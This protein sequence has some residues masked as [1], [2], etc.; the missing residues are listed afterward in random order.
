MAVAVGGGYRR[1]ALQVAA[2]VGLAKGSDTCHATQEE[3]A[4][5]AAAA[6]KTVIN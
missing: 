2:A 4:A 1:S 3:V 5:A 6:T